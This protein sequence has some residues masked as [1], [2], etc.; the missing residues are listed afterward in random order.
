MEPYVACI[1]GPLAGRTFIL[2]NQPLTIGRATNNLV[3]ITSP[4]ASR[5]HAYI[6]REGTVFVIYDL[7]SANGTLVNGQR[8]QRAVLQPGDLIEIGDEVF[9]FEG[10]YH[11]AILSPM[12]AQGQSPSTLPGGQMPTLS[13][14]PPAAHS[15]APPYLPAVEYG[16]PST[17]QSPMTVSPP[18][19]RSRGYTCLL[20]SVIIS[21]FVFGIGIAFTSLFSFFYNTLL[22]IPG[23]VPDFNSNTSTLGDSPVYTGSATLDSSQTA[24]ILL[25]D[26]P[27]IEVPQGAVPLNP[28]GTSGSLTFS[29]ALAPEQ[30]VSLPDEMALSGPLYQF[31]PEGVVFAVPVR[32]TLPIPDGT[33]PERVMGLVTY[34]DQG[35]AWVTIPGVVD[36]AART[37]SAEV[38]HFS[39]YGVYSFI[40]DD[41]GSWQR[42]H[43]GW[44]VI[45]NHSVPGNNFYPMCKHLPRTLY[46]NVCVLNPSSSPLLLS[47]GRRDYTQPSQ[48]SFWLPAGTYQVIHSI[49][50]SEMNNDPLYVPC[51][52]WW[53]KTPQVIDLQPGQTIYFADFPLE[54]GT[55]MTA[56]DPYTCTGTPASMPDSTDTS[57]EVPPGSG[58]CPMKINGDWKGRFVLRST[59]DSSLQIGD[60]EEAVL[61]FQ[62][63]GREIEFQI[64]EPELSDWAS[65]TCS[66]QDGKYV[67]TVP[68]PEDEDSSLVF[69]LQFNGDNQMIGDIKRIENDSYLDAD[70]EL[71][72]Q[73]EPAGSDES[74][75]G[76]F[77][78][79]C[80]AMDGNWEMTMDL[81]TSTNPDVPTGGTR[82]GVL[83]LRVESDAVYAQWIE[84]DRQSLTSEGTCTAQGDKRYQLVFQQQIPE[85]HPPQ[86]QPP[87]ETI[88]VPLNEVLAPITF[89]VQFESKDRMSGT[90]RILAYNHKYESRV[91]MLRR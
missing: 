50:M 16:A 26:G 40:G 75:D 57:H 54:D 42:R 32:I 85:L 33:D 9:R 86:L 74:N 62:T 24:T 64:L 20:I 70:A 49:F 83:S 11:Q 31:E 77:I 91:L 65:G 30:P 14:T 12:G 59:N 8:V 47:F 51:Y 52:G 3:V 80:A 45:E 38:T 56:F 82:Q 58:I 5:H 2:G 44:F 71:L 60:I 17:G 69:T 90:L 6:Q 18:R 22:D 25:P 1:R 27:M 13:T 41:P 34:D 67:I 19:A 46:V 43:G 73:G 55:Y 36:A 72:R 35:D 48:E 10:E 28:D 76:A 23:T 88:Q 7:G 29:V 15:S 39:P 53:V 79:S 61:R 68:H 21:M 81:L 4:R 89:E 78:A 84:G 63:D 37:V 87:S 66:V